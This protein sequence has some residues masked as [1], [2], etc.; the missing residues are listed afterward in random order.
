MA[1]QCETH[2]KDPCNICDAGT[3]EVYVVTFDPLLMGT[4]IGGFDWFHDVETAG[5]R[6]HEL[7]LHGDSHLQ[8]WQREVPANDNRE[9][10][11]D[12]LCDEGNG[13]ADGKLLMDSHPHTSAVY[14]DAAV[15]FEA[16]RKTWESA[17]ACELRRLV[18]LHAPTA[19]SIEVSYFTPEIG[20][21]PCVGFT[22]LRDSEGEE[23]GIAI[24][25]EVIFTIEGLLAE[26]FGVTY[27]D[28][29]DEVIYQLDEN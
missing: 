5:T 27:Q 11:T 3:K 1:H 17:V 4:G 2:G 19:A 22:A 8:L 21:G 23:V 6:Y 14:R 20:F 16:A 24:D 12:W 15:E 10:I 13:P 26:L 9:A 7:L 25:G 29:S 18:R 28:E